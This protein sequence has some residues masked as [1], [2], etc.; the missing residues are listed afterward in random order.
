MPKIIPKNRAM[1]RA[2]RPCAAHGR[3]S[4]RLSDNSNIAQPFPQPST[5]RFP[6]P[7]QPSETST[8]TQPSLNPLSDSDMQSPPPTLQQPRS[9]YPSCRIQELHDLGPTI[10]HHA[11]KL[12]NAPPSLRCVTTVPQ[13]Q[14]TV[15][16]PT[17][18]V[19]A[20]VLLDNPVLSHADIIPRTRLLYQFYCI[21]EL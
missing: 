16:K 20:P 5:N 19:I 10:L 11:L 3:T 18:K 14:R 15:R 1:R 12:S 9:N 2:T 4:A 13:R 7:R 8:H 21:N 6:T 17:D